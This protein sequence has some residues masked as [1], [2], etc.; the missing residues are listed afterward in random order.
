MKRPSSLFR[1]RPLTDDLLER[2]LDA[3]RESYLFSPSFS[4]MND[5][6]EAFYETGGP[7]DGLFDASV[8]GAGKKIEDLYAQFGSILTEMGLVSFSTSHE[9]LPL[10]AYYASDFAGMCLEFDRDTLAIGDF[11]D[12]RL[13]RVVYDRQALPPVS[14]ID[15]GKGGIEEALIARV[16]RKRIEWAHEQ[17]W[18]IVVGNVGKKYHLDDALRRVYL[19]PRVKKNHSARI[20]EVL[21]HRPVEIFQGEV[22]GFNLVFRSVKSAVEPEKCEG[23]GSRRFDV[24]KDLYAESEL[25]DYLTVPYEMLVEKCRIDARRPNVNGFSGI[26]LTGDNPPKVYYWTAFKLRNG[27][28]AYQKQYFDKNLKLLPG[29]TEMK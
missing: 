2:E 8:E 21:E 11:Q 24:G 19:G 20:F 15:F 28:V 5:P 1:Y 17:E 9:N 6:M 12:G 23:V 3:L 10:W 27:K 14:I 29:G 25:R 13:R 18:R 26:D 16:I 22:N 7:I 4:M